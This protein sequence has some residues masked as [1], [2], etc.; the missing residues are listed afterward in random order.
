MKAGLAA[1]TAKKSN[2][3]VYVRDMAGGRGKPLAT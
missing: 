1:S 3:D 2:L